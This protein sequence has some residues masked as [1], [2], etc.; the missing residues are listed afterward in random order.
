MGP[1]HFLNFQKISNQELVSIIDRGIELKNSSEPEKT[2][3]GKT[4]GLVFEQPSTRTRVSFEVGIS[5]MGGSSLFLSGNELQLSR[6]EPIS[7]TAKVLSSM[8]DVIVLRT[9]N[10]EKLE[11]FSQNSSVPLINGLSNLFHP[12]QIMADLMTFREISEGRSLEKVC[13][14]GDGNNVCHS[15]IEAARLLNFAFREYKE[16]NFFKKND[17]VVDAKVWLGNSS[18]VS[19][20]VREDISL[21]L[22]SIEL[23]NVRVTASWKEPIFAPIKKNQEVGELKI[24]LSDK[25][26]I[27]YPLYVSNTIDKDT[28]LN[29]DYDYRIKNFSKNENYLKNSEVIQSTAVELPKIISEAIFLLTIC[30]LMIFVYLIIKDKN[31][32]LTIS[33][34]LLGSIKILTTMTKVYSELSI[35]RS[36]RFSVLKLLNILRREN[37]SKS[38]ALNLSD[39]NQK[40]FNNNGFEAWVCKFINSGI[41][42]L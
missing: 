4:L 38:Y 19:L 2:L 6:G 33:T 23:R 20:K 34:F 14:I 12:C 36:K 25:N 8:L 31:A 24:N 42:F 32:V 1:K 35:F 17:N 16:I 3:I 18:R 40:I 10:H 13:W 37:K 26:I 41:T 5:D 15:Y 27:T 28:I 39:I 29:S 7:D 11:I 22:N 30:L 21:L 9:D